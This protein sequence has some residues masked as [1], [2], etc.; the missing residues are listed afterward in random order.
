VPAGQGQG[1]GLSPY[2]IGGVAGTETVVLQES[3]MP[4]HNHQLTA[5]TV[6]QGDNRIPNSSLNLGNTQ[7]YQT[8]GGTSTTL[9]AAAI[10]PS[11][12][13][14]AHDNMMPYLTL[15]ICICIEGLFPKR[16]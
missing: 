2:A 16:N 13:S 15:N 3:E 4:S 14:Q 1:P 11:G 5:Q 10:A 6:D 9:N 8:V 12:G 7:I